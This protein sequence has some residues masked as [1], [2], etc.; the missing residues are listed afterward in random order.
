MINVG[1]NDVNDSVLTL[2]DATRAAAVATELRANLREMF[3]ILRGR[4]DHP[5]S[6]QN[7]VVLVDDIYDPTDGTGRIPTT[8][9]DGFCGTLQNPLF[10]DALRA[11]ALA[12]LAMINAAIAAEVAAQ[13]GV[14]VRQSDAFLGHGMN[15]GS[16]RWLSGDCTHPM[17]IG[18]DGM[19]RE[20]WEALTGERY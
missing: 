9:R 2:I 10:T 1:G 17:D 13:G 12:N 3:S 7:L 11:T 18:H 4:Y 19:R 15:S 16:A 6:G 20:I 5:S 14:L 8:F